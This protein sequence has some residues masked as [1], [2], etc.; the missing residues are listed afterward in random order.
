MKLRAY[1]YDRESANYSRDALEDLLDTLNRNPGVTEINI[2]A[3]SMGNWVTLEALR[4]RYIRP[5]RFIDKVKNVMLVAPDVDVDVF[6]TQIR[7]MGSQGPRFALFVSQDDKALA[8][9]KAMWGGAPRSAKSIRRK[10]LSQR[11]GAGQDRGL[12]F[13]RLKKIGDNAHDRAF[14]DITSVVGMIKQRLRDGQQ[15]T[16]SRSISTD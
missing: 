10:T 14:E 9:S 4:S 1:Y 7:R 15:M 16:D 6:Q 2:L 3:H 13:E 11:V 8:L 12:R 5:A